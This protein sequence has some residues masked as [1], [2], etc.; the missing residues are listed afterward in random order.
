MYLRRTA[1]RKY[2]LITWTKIVIHIYD[3]PHESENIGSISYGKDE[4]GSITGNKVRNKCLV[5]KLA[6]PI[7][8]HGCKPIV[9]LLLKNEKGHNTCSIIKTINSITNRS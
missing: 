6:T 1:T 7:K 3:F 9:S 2:S 8:N 4:E 5:A